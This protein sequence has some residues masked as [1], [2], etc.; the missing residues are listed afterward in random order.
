MCVCIYIN[1]YICRIDCNTSAPLGKS[2]SKKRKQTVPEKLEVRK[3]KAYE[4]KQ[5]TVSYRKHTMLYKNLP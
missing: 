5:T 4:P 1:M 2:K 3:R